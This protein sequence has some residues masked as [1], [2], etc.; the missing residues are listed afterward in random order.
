MRECAP[1]RDSAAGNLVSGQDCRTLGAGRPPCAERVARTNN[2]RGLFKILLLTYMCDCRTLS[3]A[4]IPW[5]EATFEGKRLRQLGQC[6]SLEL[7]FCMCTYT[8]VC[9]RQPCSCLRARVGK[10]IIAETK[11]LRHWIHRGLSPAWQRWCA[12]VAHRKRIKGKTKNVSVFILPFQCGPLYFI[13][14]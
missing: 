2:G 10:C 11:A 3:K 4:F 6:E 14:I 13:F 12:F 5:A 8:R 9:I 7:V 1:P